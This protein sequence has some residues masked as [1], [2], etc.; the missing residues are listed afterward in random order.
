MRLQL[1]KQ[2]VILMIEQENQ[3]GLPEAERSRALA[4]AAE[5]LQLVE[6]TEALLGS[7]VSPEQYAASV[8]NVDVPV[9]VID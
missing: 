5:L 4:C 3:S 6:N 8:G 2:I 1:T 7:Y 9:E